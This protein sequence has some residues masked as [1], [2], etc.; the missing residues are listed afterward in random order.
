MDSFSEPGLPV[1]TC[2]WLLECYKRETRVSMQDYLVGD[3][4]LPIDDVPSEIAI[5]LT[6]GALANEEQGIQIEE[7]FEEAAPLVVNRIHQN[8]AEEGK[9]KILNCM[10]VH[11]CIFNMKIFT[12][13]KLHNTKK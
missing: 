2:E 12:F 9:I 11:Q 10:C 6:T 4:I 1:V 7:N 8:V 3:S 5:E 13:R